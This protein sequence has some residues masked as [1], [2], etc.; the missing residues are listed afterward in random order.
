MADVL[1][2]DPSEFEVLE[3]FDF[4]EEIQK[5][6]E[7]R[8]FTLDAQLTDFFEKTL[9]KG[10]VS[11]HEIKQLK[12]LKDRFKIAYENLI[13]ATE[14]DY[15]INTT[16]KEVNVPWINPVYSSFDYKEYSYDKEWRPIFANK[17]SVNYYSRMIGALPRPFTSTE[18]G[19][20]LMTKAT[21]Y[22]P[23]GLKPVTA[24]GNYQ[25]TQTILKDDGT[26]D[27]VT[28]EI[29]NTADEIKTLGFYLG[30]RPELPRPLLDHPFL[31]SNQPSF[32]KT[33]VSLLD[34]FPSVTA[35]MEHAI[36]TTTNPY[37]T[38]KLLKL[39]DVKLNQ[40]PWVAWK[41]RFPPVERQDVAMPILELKFKRDS[42]DAPAGVLTKVYS[43]WSPG[44]DSRLWL[45]NQIDGGY[46]VSKLL[47]SESASAGSLAVSPFSE[48]PTASFPESKPEI[49]MMLTS[50]FDSFL[51][52]GIYRPVKGGSGECIPVSTIIQEKVTDAY[53]GRIAWKESTKHDMLVEY[54]KLLKQFQV[55]NVPEPVKYQKF[56]HL[57]QSERRKDVLVIQEDPNREPED[58]ADALEKI[59]RDL[60]L[61]NRLYYDVPG[62]F[63]LCL[64][65]IEVLRG[66]LE[67][68]FKFYAEWTVSIDGK[69]TCRFCGEEVNSDTFNAVKEYD[70]DGHLVMEY[71]ALEAQEIST[72]NFVNSLAEL[73]KLFNPDNAGESLLFTILTFLQVL[74][75][76]KQLVPV[77]QLIRKL[78]AG[79]KARA[80]A[81]KAIAKEKQELVEGSLGIAGAVVLL[82]AHNPF[83]VP[84]RSIGNRP[85]S[86]AGYPR[87]SDDPED[88]QLLNALLVL[89]KK[90]F[91]SFP[92]SYRGSVATILRE[93]LKKSKSLKEQSLQWIKFFAEQN[94]PIFESA[95]ERY[96]VPELQAPKNT[97][98]LPIEAVD[99]PVYQPGE[100]LEEEKPMYCKISKVSTTWSTKRLP[101]VLQAELVLQSKIEPSPYRALLEPV[102]RTVP[103][104]SVSDTNIRKRVS[105]GLP[106]G[107]PLLTEFIKTAD[108]ASFVTL[109]SRLLA[110]LS[111]TSMSVKQQKE[112]QMQI[113]QID[114]G[115][116]NS[117]I[118]DIAK[119]YFFELMH[120]VKASPPLTRTVNDALR[121]DLTLRMILLSKDAAEKEDFELRAKERNTL[122]AAFRSMNDVERELA[123]R[124]LDL[125]L[126][127]FLITNVDRERFVREL[128]YREPDEIVPIDVNRPEE[129]YNVARDYVEN[130]DQPVA[131]DGTLLEVDYGDY[132]DRAVRDYNDYTPQFDFDDD[133]L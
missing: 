38:S 93:V 14:S 30:E 9:P 71:S 4:E 124:L 133:S 13:V 43:E 74:P 112:L 80:A 130:G 117:L 61:E 39:Y 23:E 126:S 88:C 128:N 85:L 62:Q 28:V 12:Q 63:V 90:T 8:F 68:K 76:E 2:F 21:L 11:K 111:K 79:L 114:I 97:L 54:Q 86:T 59:V 57:V 56:E 33:D 19:R 20:L 125:G 106:P 25:S 36:P 34:S 105:L 58:K 32:V 40:I 113:T 96:E 29:P 31:K 75:D 53:K 3:T 22:N 123:Q 94:K 92:G 118:R 24:L 44:Y 120:T 46:F 26:Y 116:S 84:K 95:R 122:K 10:K 103:F 77:L 67:D 82:Q 42:A 73:K 109:T 78:S 27:T 87:D 72:D 98:V 110:V 81:S 47:L 104:E 129:G 70:E 49:C 65:T 64:H 101:S 132:G 119:G 52:S 1:I 99:D 127:E 17:R 55:T 6:E 108:G 91:E 51:S 107:F 18:D 37:E 100:T 89:L 131:Q 45:S 83:L 50:N 35:I 5:P 41:E 66:A 121:T 7:T 60:T 48:V 16:R 15:V 69:R 115:E 102:D